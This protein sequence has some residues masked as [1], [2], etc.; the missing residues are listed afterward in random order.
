[1]LECG[2]ELNASLKI[3]ARINIQITLD[4]NLEVDQTKDVSANF[5]PHDGIVPRALLRGTGWYSGGVE[6]K[7]ITETSITIRF[8][9]STYKPQKGYVSYDLFFIK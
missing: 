5:D 8:L 3:V 4:E 7:E 9:N 6:I 2:W 1:M